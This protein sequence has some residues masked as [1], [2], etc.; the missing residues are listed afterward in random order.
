MFSVNYRFAEGCVAFR[1]ESQRLRNTVKSILERLGLY[2]EDV[3]E[4]HGQGGVID[5]ALVSERRSVP[6]GATLLSVIKRPQAYDRT[7]TAWH[8]DG[9]LYLSNES[10]LVEVHFRSQRIRGYI[11]AQDVSDT[12][13]ARLFLTWLLT[14]TIAVVLR[15]QGVFS[16]HAAA[17]CKGEDGV[18]VVAPSDCGKSTLSYSL[19]RHG[20]DYLSDDFVVLHDEAGAVEAAPFRRTFGLDVEAGD[21]FPELNRDWERPFDEEAKWAVSVET[22]YPGRQATR[23]VPRVLLFPEIVDR[24]ETEVRKISPVEALHRLVQQSGLLPTTPGTSQRQVDCLASLVKQTRPYRL[25]SGRDLLEEP[26]KAAAA[27]EPLLR[28]SPAAVRA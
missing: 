25:F 11:Y 17:L 22:L 12:R 5:L 27:I 19:V 13:E 21:F 14:S 20:W 10:S 3:A 4:G 23:C 7:F 24:R 18:L 9:T 8:E 15:E 2:P 16:M 26:Q 6:E 1:I 28:Q